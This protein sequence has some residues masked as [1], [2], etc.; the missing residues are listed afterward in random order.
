MEDIFCVFF[1]FPITSLFALLC[2]SLYLPSLHLLVMRHFLCSNRFCDNFASFHVNFQASYYY[3][4]IFSGYP[5]ISTRLIIGTSLH[6]LAV[7]NKRRKWRLHLYCKSKTP[8]PMSYN[9]G[10]YHKITCS[11]IQSGCTVQHKLLSPKF[12]R[13]HTAQSV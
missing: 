6:G 8:R 3:W 4:L 7:E 1:F 12:S 5:M 13:L 9:P 2:P 11:L 10:I